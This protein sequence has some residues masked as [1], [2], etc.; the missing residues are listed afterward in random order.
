[1]A[2]ELI[3]KGTR[4]AICLLLTIS[5]ME[6]NMTD[7]APLQLAPFFG[8]LL[9]GAILKTVETQFRLNLQFSVFSVFLV[10][11]QDSTL[12]FESIIFNNLFSTNQL[13]QLEIVEDT[14][15]L[16]VRPKIDFFEEQIFH[17]TK[18]LAELSFDG[19]L[20]MGLSRTMLENSIVVKDFSLKIKLTFSTFVP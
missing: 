12:W 4:N 17:K 5:A 2:R 1:M 14:P 9:T 10:A 20:E 7:K 19:A 15:L 16:L 11:L 3:E 18:D 8:Q 13:E 6:A